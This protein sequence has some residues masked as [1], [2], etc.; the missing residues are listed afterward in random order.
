MI[1]RTASVADKANYAVYA[2]IKGVA[3]TQTV[4]TDSAR[5][6]WPVAAVAFY[7]LLLT[8]VSSIATAACASASA[9]W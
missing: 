9:P 8:H 4:L 5:M 2:V 1:R 3:R 7:T 6:A